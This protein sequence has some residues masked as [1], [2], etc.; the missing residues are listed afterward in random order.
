RMYRL[1]SEADEVLNR[2]EPGDKTELKRRLGRPK[3]QD[4]A[5]AP[6]KGDDK[7]DRLDVRDDRLRLYFDLGNAGLI[8]T[9]MREDV[10]V[11]TSMGGVNARW[12][13]DVF[14]RGRRL[15]GKEVLSNKER[16]FASK[17]FSWVFLLAIT[18]FC[19]ELLIR[20]LLRLA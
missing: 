15:R 16:P 7:E 18:L 8:P 14:A 9:C 19:T 4:E 3:A 6:G 13:E 17:M 5:A 10:P 1:A 20:K 11:Q 2:M 12:G